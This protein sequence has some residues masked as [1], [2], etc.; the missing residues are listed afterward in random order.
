MIKY[1]EEQTD[2]PTVGYPYSMLPYYTAMEKE[3]AIGTLSNADESQNNN[4]IKEVKQKY[5]LY[6]SISIKLFKSAN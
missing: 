4:E 5:K 1:S 2:K 6:D 3:W